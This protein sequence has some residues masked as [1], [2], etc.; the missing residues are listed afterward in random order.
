MFVKI[1]GI[2]NQEDALLATA[3]G[4]DAVGFVF[5]PSKRQ[6]AA[7]IVRD[8]VRQLPPEI[9]TVGVFRDQG[10]ERVVEVVNTIGLR[11]AQLHGNESPETCRWIAERVPVTIRALPA[12]SPDLRRIDDFGADL[13][14][15]DSP[16]PGSGTV[17]DWSLAEG[18]PSNR[19]VILAGGLDPENVARAITKVRPFGVDVSSGVEAESGRKDPRLLRAFLEAARSVQFEDYDGGERRPFDWKDESWG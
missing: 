4:A 16:V 2:T 15:L 6:M 12:G 10:R 3:L 18:A 11:A 14:L 13:I 8:I 1:C 9:M 19:P 7:P 17:F 5:A